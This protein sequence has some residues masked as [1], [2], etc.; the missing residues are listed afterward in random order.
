AARP[1]VSQDVISN[2]FNAAKKSGAAIPVIP[3]TDT[4]KKTENGK[5]SSTPRR[6]ELV[7]VQTPQV[8]SFNLF[9]ELYKK[10]PME[11]D[12]TDD[13]AVFEYFGGEVAA[14]EGSQENIKITFPVDLKIAEAILAG[15]E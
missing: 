13:A 3:L 2:V 11:K 14:V 15:M 10:F 1:L 6:S 5:I 7:R 8:F 4:V 12:I 9:Y